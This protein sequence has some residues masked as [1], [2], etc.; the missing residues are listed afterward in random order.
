MSSFELTTRMQCI[1][2]SA[3]RSATAAVAY[4]AADRIHCDREGRTHDYTRKQGVERSGIE[5]P[6]GSPEMTRAEL[7]NLAEQRET[8]RNSQTAREYLIS[9]PHEISPAGRVAVVREVS[10]HM[11]DRFG[12]AVDW[13]L[14]EPGRDGDERNFHAHIMLTTR[15][16][17]RGQLTEKTRELDDRRTGPEL[18]KELR[19]FTAEAMNRQLDREYPGG[20]PVT[21]EWASFKERG[22]ERE[23]TQHEGPSRIRDD[24]QQDR[25]R[26]PRHERERAALDQR[27]GE[28]MHDL[29]ERQEQE[30]ERKRVQWLQEARTRA[31]EIRERVEA[32]ERADGPLRGFKRLAVWLTG[33][34]ARYNAARLERRAERNDQAQQELEAL[35][36]EYRDRRLALHR[37]HTAVRD[38]VTARND[39]ERERLVDRHERER[40]QDRKS[41]REAKRLE[42]IKRSRRRSPSRERDQSRNRGDSWEITRDLT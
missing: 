10:R 22:I 34:T 38:D 23:P 20:R 25:D 27:H 21:V 14:H 39:Q 18:V 6:E 28:R 40:E 8:R 29:Q 42:R 17:E 41:R 16:M 5:L 4:R 32:A 1:K 31:K 15:R 2:R 33:R 36:Q 11:V 9:L 12:V 30:R 37:E 26:D 13:S 3:G 19:L 24:R 7:W 35:R